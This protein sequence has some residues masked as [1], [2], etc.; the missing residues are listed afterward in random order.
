MPVTR[1]MVDL[2]GVVRNFWETTG[3]ASLIFKDLRISS[4]RGNCG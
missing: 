4:R 2:I 1:V 3:I